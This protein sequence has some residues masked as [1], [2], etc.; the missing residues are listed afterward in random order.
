MHIE[1]SLK[2]ALNF[3][4]MPILRIAAVRSQRPVALGGIKRGV[5]FGYANGTTVS[6]LEEL[7]MAISLKPLGNLASTSYC[8][9]GLYRQE[10]HST[11]M[12]RFDLYL[13]TSAWSDTPA[14]HIY[15]ISR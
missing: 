13:D 2:H 9:D 15:S 12:S 6:V 7:T 8:T 3:A 14:W 4:S 10:N 1:K 5:H 11:L